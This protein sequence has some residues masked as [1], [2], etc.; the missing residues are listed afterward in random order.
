MNVRQDEKANIIGDE[1]EPSPLQVCLPADPGIPMTT[2][3]GRGPPAYQGHRTLAKKRHVS[4]GLTDN[5]TETQIMVSVHE[6]IPR[7][8]LRSYNGTDNKSRA[9]GWSLWKVYTKRRRGIDRHV[10]VINDSIRK[11]QQKMIAQL[12]Q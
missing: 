2:L 7:V 6:R 12:Y 5:D 3:E 1:A 9:C 8:T 4:Q 11:S 10:G